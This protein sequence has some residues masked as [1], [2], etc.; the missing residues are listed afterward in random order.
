MN[1]PIIPVNAVPRRSFLKT[2]TG[3]AMAAPLGFPA[4]TRAANLNS[5]LQHASIGVGGMMG[6]NDLRTF[7][8][9]GK[10]DMVAICDVDKTQLD[11]AQKLAPGARSYADWREMLEKEGDK[12]DS[13]NIAVPDH[14]HAAI[15]MAAIL[16]K[17]HVYCQKPLCHDVAEIRALTIAA[18]KAGIVTQLGTQHASGQGDLMA[19]AWLREGIIGKIKN[20]YLCSN[21]TGAEEYR[22]AGPRPSAPVAPPESLNWDLWLGTA[23]VRPY[24]P[25]IYHPSKWRGWLDFGTG[26]SG[27]I[28]CHIFDAVWKGLNLTAPVKVSAEVQESW[29]NSPERRADTWPQSN[30]ITWTFAANPAWAGPELKVEWFDGEFFPPEEVRKLY[31]G[32]KYPEESAMVIGTEGAMLIPHQHGPQLL[33]GD[34]FKA[35]ARPKV[36][37]RNHYNHFVDCILDSS[38]TESN[39][40]VSGPMAEC[41]IL[42]TVGIRAAGQELTWDAPAMK[43]GGS[44]EAAKW[45]QREYREGWKVPGVGDVA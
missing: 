11:A 29:K 27:D 43:V 25:T 12:I 7:L 26:W 1:K 15:A 20:V 35:A 10:L 34:K 42:G 18:K 30:H 23:P 32:S 22:P 38:M 19:V 21:R 16:R 41:I 37:V 5:R 9:H 44:A 31:T 14:M 45:L 39:F 3:A 6:G 33:P 40:A 8:Q 2:L 36:P 24:A 4:I 28:G 17:K 13:V